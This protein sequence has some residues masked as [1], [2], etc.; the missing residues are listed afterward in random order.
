VFVFIDRKAR[1]DIDSQQPQLGDCV[2]DW[3]RIGRLTE[4]TT[5]QMDNMGE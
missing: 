4:K 2:D 5:I 1:A 3:L